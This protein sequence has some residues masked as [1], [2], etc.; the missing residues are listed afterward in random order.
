MGSPPPENLATDWSRDRIVQA[1]RAEGIPCFA[2][3]CGEIYLERAFAQHGFPG[4][5]L[6]VAKELGETSLMFLVHPTLTRKDISDTC[7]AVRKVMMRTVKGTYSA[8]AYKV[9]SY[10]EDVA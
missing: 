6:P 1:I 2:G 9:G 8:S 5:R 7:L 4:T 10:A 3:G